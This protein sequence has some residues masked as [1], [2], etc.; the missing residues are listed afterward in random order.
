MEKQGLTSASN[1]PEIMQAKKKCED[2]E[3]ELAKGRKFASTQYV[4]DYLEET[5]IYKVSYEDV[6]YEYEIKIRLKDYL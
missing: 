2:L 3:D 4:R 6:K 5:H 1:S